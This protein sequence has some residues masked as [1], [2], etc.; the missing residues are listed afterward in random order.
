[1]IR[2]SRRVVVLAVAGA[3][4]IAPVISGCG[5]GETPQ[6][7]FP[8]RLSEGVNVTVP[9]DKPTSSQIDLRNMFLLGPASGEAIKPGGDMPLYG[10]LINQVQGRQDRLVSVSSPAF[11]GAKIAGGSLTLPP[12]A[13][14][15]TGSMVKLL[16][17]PPAASP[18]ATPSGRASGGASPEPTAGAGS[19]PN[20]STTPTS[21]NTTGSPQSSPTVTPGPGDQPLVVLTGLTQA[22]LEPGSTVPV[23]MQ[24]EKAGA[25]EF[26]VPIVPHQQDYLT[27][28]LAS[29]S[30]QASGTPSPGTTSPSGSPSPGA[31]GE[32]TPGASKT[33]GA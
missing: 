13:A 22:Q 30:G 6:S 23:R 12:A 14:D 3:V 24:F 19:T 4:A 8:T 11:G 28:P 1:M 16:G 15:G 29:P 20:T 2:N 31:S 10:V 17:K 7:A 21:Q 26:Q 18:S 5:A 32:P 25:V 9:K 27:Y 33:P